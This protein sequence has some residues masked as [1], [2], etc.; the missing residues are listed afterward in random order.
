MVRTRW[1]RERRMEKFEDVLDRS[2]PTWVG[3]AL[4]E[5]GVEH[6]AAY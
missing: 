4:R 1:L 5:L 3:L 2:K 6:I